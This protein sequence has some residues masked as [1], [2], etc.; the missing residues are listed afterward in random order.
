MYSEDKYF[1]A[2][3][4]SSSYSSVSAIALRKRL[5]EDCQAQEGST[6]PRRFLLPASFHGVFTTAGEAGA[7]SSHHRCSFGLW[8]EWSR[9][10]HESFQ[11]QAH[12][13]VNPGGRVWSNFPLQGP[14]FLKLGTSRAATANCH[15]SGRLKLQKCIV[16]HFGNQKSKT[17][18]LA[19]PRLCS[20]FW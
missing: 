7:P 15:K 16:P 19:R 4:W 1:L 13:S 5:L 11:G 10:K 6:T 9:E 12:L 8:G 3:L 14:E 2:R 20:S 18:V 17:K